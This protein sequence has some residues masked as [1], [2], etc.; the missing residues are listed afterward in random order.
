MFSYLLLGGA[1]QSLAIEVGLINATTPVWVLLLG[2]RMD[3]GHLT[4]K[5][6]VGLVLAFAGTL[7]II[8]KGQLQK[9]E[10]YPSVIG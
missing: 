2:L 4:A 6:K 5:I 10:L 9:A 1:Y 3:G 7:L 8:T